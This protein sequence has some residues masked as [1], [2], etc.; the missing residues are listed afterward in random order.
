MQSS[1]LFKHVDT[2][3]VE[4]KRTDFFFARVYKNSIFLLPSLKIGD[5]FLCASYLTI[6]PNILNNLHR[7]LERWYKEV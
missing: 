7:A 6:V 1:H 2:P 3:K 5:F 4:T